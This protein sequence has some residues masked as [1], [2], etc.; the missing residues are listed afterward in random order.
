MALRC[1]DGRF[2][3]APM[4]NLRAATSLTICA[5]TV[6]VAGSLQRET[7]VPLRRLDF[8]IAAGDRQLHKSIQD[9]KDWRNPYLVIRAD[10]IAM[11]ASGIPSGRKTVATAEL[12][13]TLI[14]LPANAW[15]YGKGV[16]VQ[17]IG[18]RAGDGRDD[19]S[20]NRNREAT[21]TILKVLGVEVERWP[22][23]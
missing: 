10:G 7:T 11:I 22:S 4:S 23:A 16:A 14:E 8:Q 9:A 1:E 20:V 2:Q 21:L 6:F 12:H 19:D 5:A 13:Q 3:V 18:I 17:D 15:P